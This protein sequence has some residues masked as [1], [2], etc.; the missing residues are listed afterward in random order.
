MKKIL[1]WLLVL[2]TGCATTANYE[3]SL[4]SWVGA[5]ESSLVDQWGPPSSVYESSGVKYLTYNKS[6]SGYVP[7]VAPSY[8]TT[9]VGNTA[10][11]S[12]VGGSAGYGF[13]NSCTTTFSIRN[14]VISSWRWEG[15][16][17]RSI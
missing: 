16:A 2:L 7:G 6:R 15:N 8:Q 10:Y 1:L 13:T 14:N 5:S 12:A 17:C 11:T 3:K 4:N 9:Y